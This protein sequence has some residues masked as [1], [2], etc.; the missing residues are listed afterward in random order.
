MQN[1]I[2]DYSEQKVFVGID[3]H[4]KQWAITSIIEGLPIRS[5]VIPPDAELL[6][7]YLNNYYPGALYKLVYE[8]GFSG[9]WLSQYLNAQGYE[10][11]VVHPPDIP[12]S[13]KDKAQKTDKRD[14]KRLALALMNNQLQGIFIPTLEQQEYRNLT[15]YRSDLVANQT[16]LKNKIKASLNYFGIVYPESATRNWSKSFI[17]K[18]NSTKFNNIQWD[19]CFHN[20]IKRI[21][22]IKAE[23]QIIN[24]KIKDLSTQSE[25]KE[26]VKLLK[27]V[28]GFGI[29]SSMIFLTEIIDIK[30]FTNLDSLV[31]YCGICPKEHSSGESIRKTRQS[32]RGNKMLKYVIVEVSWR[33]ITK[34]TALGSDYLT[35]KKRM[36]GQKAIIKIA[37]KLL[38]KVRHIL[39]KKESYKIM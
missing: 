29:I 31:S 16:S 18:L 21:L 2:K 13:N 19:Y 22:E 11:I 14:S 25:F 6:I 27:T 9:F 20:Q 7:K 38:S 15:R 12:I 26:N 1:N 30:R 5:S 28:P 4:K 33:A 35:Y 32:M 37:R 3:V 8:A 39:V 36:P 10:T 17:D 24:T 34:D 23:I